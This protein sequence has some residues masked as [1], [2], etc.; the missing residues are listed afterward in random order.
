[1]GRL[2]AG[3]GKR[4]SKVIPK[5]KVISKMPYTNIKV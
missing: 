4:Y 5:G 2:E 3:E 1:V